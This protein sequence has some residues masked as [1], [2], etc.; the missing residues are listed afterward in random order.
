MAE[1]PFT[2]IIMDMSVVKLMTI[3]IA[4]FYGRIKSQRPHLYLALYAH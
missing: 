4:V 2:V 3:I 1:V